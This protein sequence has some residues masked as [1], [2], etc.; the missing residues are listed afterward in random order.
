MSSGAIPTQ[1]RV[2]LVKDTQ[3]YVGVQETPD[4]GPNQVLVKGERKMTQITKERGNNLIDVNNP[5]MTPL[6]QWR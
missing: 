4:I 1:A 6:V 3:T 2:V 5:L